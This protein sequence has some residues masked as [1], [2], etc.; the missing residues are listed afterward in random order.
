[1]PAR[2][3]VSFLITPS[4]KARSLSMS[5]SRRA[6]G[7]AVVGQVRHLVHHRRGVQQCLRRN[8]AD[9][10]ADAAERRR[11]ARRA[12]SSCRGR[13]CGRPPNSRPGRRRARASRTR[14]RP[15]RRGWLRPARH[16][17]LR[18]RPRRPS[19]RPVWRRA[20]PPRRRRAALQPLDHQDHRA[21]ADLVAELD[22]ELLHDARPGD[23]G[24]SI[25]A[26]SDSTMISAVS[27]A[28]GLA[29]L[30]QQLDHRDILEVADVGDLHFDRFDHA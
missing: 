1:M 14:C 28:I 23:D 20:R 27:T 8:A 22:L 30:D 12:R 24:I 6:V 10:Q 9:V 5:I 15:C 21:F 17:A 25:E 19:E 4:L 3:P 7:D 11:S 29:R 26:L 18:L 2:P 13:R 16:G